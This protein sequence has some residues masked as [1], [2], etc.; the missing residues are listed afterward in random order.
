[1]Y[2]QG[3]R[4]YSSIGFM[5]VFLI[6]GYGSI[7]Q[8]FV[9]TQCGRF[10]NTLLDLF[11]QSSA[12]CISGDTAEFCSRRLDEYQRTLQVIYSGLEEY[13]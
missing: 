9:Y 3:G 10:F 5:E 2:G 11:N 8:P 1:M 7:T 6:L 12:Y 13:R 4:D